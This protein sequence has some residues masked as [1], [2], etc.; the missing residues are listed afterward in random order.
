MSHTVENIDSVLLASGDVVAAPTR[1]IPTAGVLHQNVRAA[2]LQQ[3]IFERI[4][5]KMT[6]GII[7]WREHVDIPKLRYSLGFS[8]TRP[9]ISLLKFDF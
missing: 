2:D 4:S 5:R 8:S 6:N 1:R 7:A 9:I 3:I